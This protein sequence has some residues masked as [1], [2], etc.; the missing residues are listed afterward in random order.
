MAGTKVETTKTMLATE[1][2]QESTEVVE[3]LGELAPEEKKDFL[4]FIQGIRF[5]KSMTQKS[6][7]QIV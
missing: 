3:F 6:T 7:A 1:N 5:A 4:A 2:Q